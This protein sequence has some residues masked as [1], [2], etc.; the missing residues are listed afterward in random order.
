MSTNHLALPRLR[1]SCFMK[2]FVLLFTSRHNIFRNCPYCIITG[3]LFS[4]SLYSTLFLPWAIIIFLIVLPKAPLL[5]LTRFLHV[6][7]PVFSQ[8][9]FITYHKFLDYLSFTYL[10]CLPSSLFSLSFSVIQ[11]S[12]LPGPWIICIY[13]LTF[14][15]SSILSSYITR[16]SSLE[17]PT[18]R[19]ILLF[20][21][22]WLR[23]VLFRH[24]YRHHRN[25]HH[26]ISAVW[27]CSSSRD[28]PSSSSLRHYAIDH[29]VPKSSLAHVIY[30]LLY[31]GF[32]ELL[33]VPL[34]E[35]FW[36]VSSKQC[37]LCSSRVSNPLI[38]QHQPNFPL[39]SFKCRIKFLLVFFTSRHKSSAI[40]ILP[41][42]FLILFSDKDN[43]FYKNRSLTFFPLVSLHDQYS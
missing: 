41:M 34:S 17:V 3:N 2:Q 33:C 37:S 7:V 11:L 5:D 8:I 38:L 20:Q 31:F 21:S 24:L 30:S 32:S 42:F 26:I 12:W 1:N 29:F 43:E 13:T 6:T 23:N 14:I 39:A 4:P 9:T 28:V 40:M 27:C 36:S 18:T 35:S 15:L 16:Y 25:L 22:K 10:L 19:N